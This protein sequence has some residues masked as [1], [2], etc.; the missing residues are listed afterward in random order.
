MKKT[1]QLVCAL[2]CSLF[3]AAP[4][5]TQSKNATIA[6]TGDIMMGTT[7]PSVQLPPQEGRQLFVDVAPL[8][9]SADIAAG[10]LEGTLCDGG[11]THK[12]ISKICYAFRTPTSFAERL[13]EA[14]YDFLSMAN[15]HARDFGE[16]GIRSTMSC[17]DR[18]GI[19]YAGIKNYPEQAIL[20]KNGITYG[21][22]AFGH[23]DYTLRHQDLDEVRRIITQ[24]VNQCDVVIVSF[25]GGA[26]GAAKARL[27]Y[28]KEV[29]CGEDR[30]S[31]REFAH[32]CVDAGADIVYGHGPHVVRALELY[33]E[34]L[35]AYSLGNFCTPYGINLG[36]ISGYA[37]LLEVKIH[38]DG[39]FQSGKIHSFIQHR[40]VGPRMDANHAVAKEMKR[41]T[42]L[43]ILNHNLLVSEDGTLARNTK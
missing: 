22:C 36:G 31:L 28:G 15:N 41:L 17:L 2:C 10:N 7:Y 4:A 1:L 35:I 21:F 19:K 23:N 12:K 33:K 16:E 27:P 8:L 34:H 18:I 37:P 40:G 11:N 25:H 20:Q 30:G 32:F 43:D 29:F 38:G 26:E 5:Q 3:A 6:L 9:R 42:Q 13:S 24:L 14:G 39:R